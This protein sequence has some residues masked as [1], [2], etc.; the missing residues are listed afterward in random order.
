ME[1]T[2]EV[3]CH[4]YLDGDLS[5]DETSAFE[6]GL[7]SRPELSQALSRAVALR[8]LFT[9][10]PPVAPPEGLEARI[11]AAL[12]L[13]TKAK[14]ATREDAA[15]ASQ[16]SSLNAVLAG[17]GWGLRGPAMAL[18]PAA[19]A[20]RA[21]AARR[22][23]AP[24]K[25]RRSWWRRLNDLGFRR[26]RR[27]SHAGRAARAG[28]GG[29]GNDPDA[30]P[31]GGA[32]GAGTAAAV[33][34]RAL[35]WS[36]EGVSVLAALGLG[37]LGLLL[38]LVLVPL[39]AVALG[40][41]HDASPEGAVR[42]EW[43]WG[44]AGFEA[45]TQGKALRLFWLRVWRFAA[46]SGEAKTDDGTKKPKETKSRGEKKK[47]PGALARLRSGVEHSPALRRMAMRLARA[48]H[49]RLSVRGVVGTG[50]PAQTAQLFAVLL[51][52]QELP[53]VEL[54][55]RPDWLDEELEV[56]VR[57]SARVWLADLLVVAAGLLLDRENRAALRAMRSA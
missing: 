11:A 41:V 38:A 24:E 19:T 54:D 53:G 37:L 55:V 15:A 23:S 48:L 25:P 12:S 34:A 9:S 17:A 47:G 32:R 57:G 10:L 35:A 31:D 26:K 39:R 52:V 13:E 40:S 29:G 46:G 42:V 1:P 22:P 45:G 33:A 18:E 36:E 50:D 5:Q 7:A 14:A 56:D 16:P 51:A 30:G 4:A 20:A 28:A 2:L 49:L 21:V 44:L 43:A 27:V 6:R 3:L 8:E